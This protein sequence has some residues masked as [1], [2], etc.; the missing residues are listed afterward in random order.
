MFILAKKDVEL[1]QVKKA[2]TQTLVMRYRRRIFRRIS[3]FGDITAAI[4]ACR[5][6]LDSGRFSIVLRDGKEGKE[7][8]RAMAQEELQALKA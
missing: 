1:L 7:V 4:A 3:H 5:E 2:Q 8:W 6:E